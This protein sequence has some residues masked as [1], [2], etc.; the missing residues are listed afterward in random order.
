MALDPWRTRPQPSWG[1]QA[2]GTMLDPEAVFLSQILGQTSSVDAA[3]AAAAGDTRR[4]ILDAFA[5]APKALNAGPSY[6][7]SSGTVFEAGPVGSTG[8]AAATRA[9]STAAGG[10][11]PFLPVLASQTA[12][13]AETAGAA[14]AGTAARESALR[15]LLNPAAWTAG[16]RATGRFAWASYGPN[17]VPNAAGNIGKL[18]AGTLGRAGTLAAGGQVAGSLLEKVWNDPNSSADNA[19]ATA[20]KGA[21]LGAAAGSLL[22]PLGTAVG[23]GLGAIGGALWGG[24]R[25][26]HQAKDFAKAATAGSKKLNELSDQLGLSSD[27]KTEL[28]RQYQIASVLASESDNPIATQKAVV[29]N[30]L[31]AL[32]TIMEE[33]K[34][35]RERMARSVALSNLLQPYLAQIDQSAQIQQQAYGRLAEQASDPTLRSLYELR[36]SY[37]AQRNASN[38]AGLVTQAEQSPYPMSLAQQAAG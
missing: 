29:S 23:G 14:I 32:P 36:G 11:S 7:P 13:A 4:R 6:I 30:L 20:L 33:D 21:G 1:T 34:A 31:G 28:L 8:A 2:I 15:Q 9:A 24:L 5:S 22:G 10:S 19:V 35:N 12:G 16:N 25:G 3:R 17:A 38:L 26:G 18:S 27:G 37:A